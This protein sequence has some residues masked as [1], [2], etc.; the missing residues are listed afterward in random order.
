[1]S[2]RFLRRS[3]MEMPITAV[4]SPGFS[5]A[6]S[7]L[8][9]GASKLAMR[10][11]R[12]ETKY[13]ITCVDRAIDAEEIGVEILLGDPIADL[14]VQA[15]EELILRDSF[16]DRAPGVG[17]GRFGVV[18]HV[19]RLRGD[20][21]LVDFFPGPLEVR[22]AGGDDT[23][24]RITIPLALLLIEGLGD[25]VVDRGRNT[26]AFGSSEPGF[27]G[28]F[29]LIDREETRDHVAY[30]EPADESHSTA[31][32]NPQ[33]VH[34]SCSSQPTDRLDCNAPTHNTRRGYRC[35]RRGVPGYHTLRSRHSHGCESLK[36]R[37]RGPFTHLNP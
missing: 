13:P 1:M 17:G 20:V 2:L 23:D 31:E 28:P 21:D 27:H 32:D 3:L 9:T 26:N 5:S 6:S 10:S 30:D 29:V 15:G 36:D 35:R 7:C 12:M 19:H 16:E 22:T 33:I 34:L 37:S 24:L 4:G 25:G 8:E 14:A 18:G 11:R